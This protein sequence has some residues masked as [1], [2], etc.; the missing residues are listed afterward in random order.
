M[1]Y[2]TLQT[3][4]P[5]FW[6]LLAVLLLV[7]FNQPSFNTIQWFPSSKLFCRSD[8][9]SALSIPSNCNSCIRYLLPQNRLNTQPTHSGQPY[10]NHL[11]STLPLIPICFNPKRAVQCLEALL[12]FLYKYLSLPRA[13]QL[14][15]RQLTTTE[16][17]HTNRQIGPRLSQ[18][19]VSRQCASWIHL[20][21]AS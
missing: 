12:L 16:P 21:P 10:S 6:L 20:C 4:Q 15:A 2:R 5:I 19:A 1:Y 17:F 14:Q 3:P 13:S 7:N 18:V 11:Y 8:L 9:S